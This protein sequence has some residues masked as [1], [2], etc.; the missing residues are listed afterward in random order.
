MAE[1]AIAKCITSTELFLSSVRICSFVSFGSE[2]S[3]EL[4]NAVILESDKTL[5]I[6]R[7]SGMRTM[8]MIH[9]NGDTLF[10]ANAYGIK[11]PIGI[12]CVLESDIP[13]LCIVPLLAFDDYGYRLGYGGGFYDVFLQEHS[14]VQTIG[15][16]FSNQYSPKE[17]PHDEH[18]MP[19]DMIITETGIHPIQNN[20]PA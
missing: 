10:D 9:V 14:H 16:A 18:D 8:D 2:I 5:L 11:E 15:I 13:T 3:T 7:I 6:P 4:L 20:K 19:M 12:P 17:L 1:Q